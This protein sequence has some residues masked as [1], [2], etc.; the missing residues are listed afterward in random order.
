[1]CVLVCTLG[2]A[3]PSRL[4]LLNGCANNPDGFGYAVYL[5]S[6]EI[7]TN[8]CMS[9]ALIIDEYLALLAGSD[10]VAS[11]FHAR[12]ETSGGSSLRN[13][14]PFTAGG[15]ERTYI[16]HNGILPIDVPKGSL[17]SDTALFAGEI[18]PALGGMAGL[19][20][21]W[22]VSFWESWIG[23][24]NK[25]AFL[26][27]DPLAPFPLTILNESAGHWE[28]GVW[29]SNRSCEY[30][31]TTFSYASGSKL[32]GALS[33]WSNPAGWDALEGGEEDYSYEALTRLTDCGICTTVGDWSEDGFCL[34]CGCCGY[35]EFSSCRCAEIEGSDPGGYDT[36][37]EDLEVS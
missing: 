13:C 14:H 15:D 5:A 20:S 31:Y 24:G 33:T 36:F 16:A 4:D 35:C 3:R 12:I 9:S 7:L 26:S 30:D 25:V 27:S 28:G 10:V 6:G 23:G 29:F 1:M 17:D 19:A 34:F 32:A 8:R 21:S 22:G 11:M 18:F 37:P 2:N